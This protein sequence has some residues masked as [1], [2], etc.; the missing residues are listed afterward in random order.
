MENITLS[1]KIKEDP[2]KILAEAINFCHAN[3]ANEAILALEKVAVEHSDD[4]IIHES[5]DQIL[6]LLGRSNKAISAFEQ[7][8]EKVPAS[9]FIQLTYAR[10]LL[11]NGRFAQSLATLDS[12]LALKPDEISALLLSAETLFRAGRLKD[13]ENKYRRVLEIEP[14][15]LA[16]NN[17]L[18]ISPQS[19]IPLSFLRNFLKPIARKFPTF[20]RF[21]LQVLDAEIRRR[22]NRQTKSM[23]QSYAEWLELGQEKWLQ[24]PNHH[25][26]QTLLISV[27]GS[28]LKLE[29][30]LNQE[31]DALIEISTDPQKTMEV[32]SRENEAWALQIAALTDSIG[33]W[34]CVLTCTLY[35]QR[36]H[37]ILNLSRF[38]EIYG[39]Y[40]NYPEAIKDIP[41]DELEEFTMGGQIPLQLGYINEHYPENY[42]DILND[43]DIKRYGTNASDETS[44]LDGPRSV[45]EVRS[46]SDSRGGDLINRLPQ[47]LNSGQDAAV[48]GS[49]DLF[50]ESLCLQNGASEVTTIRFLPFINNTTSIKSISLKEWD[51]EPKCFDLVIAVNTVDTYGLGISGENLEPDGDIGLMQRFRRMIKPGGYLALSV[52]IGQDR[53]IF[54]SARIYGVIRLP[55]LLEGWRIVDTDKYDESLL[56]G[57][58]NLRPLLMLQAVE[59]PSIDMSD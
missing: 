8:S 13:S 42:A 30:R 56:S 16:A 3:Q 34:D 51:A 44:K 52:P 17:A 1:S 11:T 43:S 35:E 38:A 2:K 40:E 28:S 7:V 15:N 18:F 45:F 50:L 26:K 5:I 12:F 10:L 24:H 19:I 58:G 14:N 48:F 21:A 4:Q 27:P 33:Y 54:N 59:F 29:D 9:D 6:A 46:Y 57:K 22:T 37:Y 23:P 39:A 55:K 53:L 20:K 47:L 49:I 32:L 41:L 25:G 31:A 36:K